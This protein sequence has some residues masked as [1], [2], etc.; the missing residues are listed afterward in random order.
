MPA[1]SA[2]DLDFVSIPGGTFEMG[3]DELSAD[4]RPVTQ[5]SLAPYRLSRNLI[6]PAQYAVCLRRGRC[7]PPIT[8]GACSYSVS[9]HENDPLTCVS[10][11]EAD[12][13]CR[14][15]DA[16]LPTE[17]EWEFAARAPG[18]R[19]GLEEIAGT[20]FTE[21]VSDAFAP[22]PGGAV[23]NPRSDAG[24]FRVV[25]GGGWSYD[26]PPALR[27]ATR[28]KRDPGFRTDGLSF[29]CAR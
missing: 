2:E 11:T 1:A 26:G 16:R 4:E 15:R 20:S 5:V 8:G 9:G 18:N 27:A 12:A 6:T 17:A 13:F 14:D 23:A 10:W 25:R 29:R 7:P 22:Y 28:E 24:L 3:T 21:W 19:F